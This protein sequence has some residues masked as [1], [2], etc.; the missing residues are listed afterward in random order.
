[1]MVACTIIA[2]SSFLLPRGAHPKI[3][4]ELLPVLAEPNQISDYDFCDYVVEGLREGAAKLRED[5]L[6]EPAQ[7]SLQG[8]L[9]VPQII[10][11]DYHEHGMEGRELLPFPRLASYSDMMLKLQIKK[12][13]ARNG[14]DAG[15]EA[16]DVPRSPAFNVA[17]ASPPQAQA[18]TMPSPSVHDATP[19]FGV[20]HEPAISQEVLDAM[21]EAMQ[22]CLKQ[23]EDEFLKMVEETPAKV[24]EEIRNK[25]DAKRHRDLEDTLGDF[26]EHVKKQAPMA[27]AFPNVSK[28]SHRPRTMTAVAQ[29]LAETS[30]EAARSLMSVVVAN[31]ETRVQPAESHGLAA[32]T[33]GVQG[34]HLNACPGV[35]VGLLGKETAVQEP[36][37]ELEDKP[38]IVDRKGKGPAIDVV[39]R[40][41]SR[42]TT[43]H[44]VLG[45][46]GSSSRDH[47]PVHHPV[48]ASVDTDMTEAV[49]PDALQMQNDGLA[50]IA[51]TTP[52]GNRRLALPG[53]GEQTNPVPLAVVPA[54]PPARDYGY[55]PFEL[56]L[57]HFFYPNHVCLDLYKSVELLSQAS[58]LSRTWFE[59]HTPTVLRIDGHKMKYQFSLHGEMMYNGLDASVRGWNDRERSMMQRVDLPNW[60]GLLPPDVVLHIENIDTDNARVVLI[61]MLSMPKLGFPLCMCRLLLFPLWLANDWSLYAFDMELTRVTVMDPLYTQVGSLVYERK[62]GATVHMLLKGLKILGTILFDGWEMDISKW[63]VRGESPGY[64]AHYADNFNA[65]ELEEAIPEVG[66]P[67]RRKRMLY[68]TIACSGNTAPHPGFMEEVEVEE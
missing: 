2:A 40:R 3:A 12:H 53:N 18:W 21:K 4:N 36:V 42:Q 65:Y 54:L 44:E 64:I 45:V 52:I 39:Y 34:P 16:A 35:L 50:G 55:S 38:M 17:S 58:E 37:D 27:A 67:L 47:V 7:L 13:A 48:V 11:C 60:R 9:V 68:E 43:M 22:H 57:Q 28:T 14:V 51:T 29:D 61:A 32:A 66:L 30:R 1:M 49:V 23:R 56:D 10:F 25:V 63:T 20:A 31:K 8:C 59:H 33:R 24:F 6:H 26:M 15:F 62:H 46:A 19:G 5:L 41:C